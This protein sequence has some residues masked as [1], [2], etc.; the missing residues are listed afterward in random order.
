MNNYNKKNPT[1][2]FR[3]ER[4]YFEKLQKDAS[5][6]KLTT[7]EKAKQILDSYLKGDLV[8]KQA[9]NELELSRLKVEKIKEEIR[10]LKIK[11]D[12]AE[13]FDKPI[14]QSATRIIKPAVKEIAEL[15][16]SPYDSS[17]KRLQ[18]T[19]CGVLFLWN[20]FDEYLQQMKEFKNHVLAKHNREFS[21][22]EKNVIDN[23]KFEGKSK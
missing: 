6:E 9:N 20:S 11:N 3:I 21:A 7:N 23:L 14:S 4:Y 1:F 10:Y 15:G 8:P 13:N 12:F 22:L 2:S 17:N 18:C 5:R 16:Q 19:S